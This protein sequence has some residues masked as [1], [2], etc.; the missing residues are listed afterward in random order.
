MQV[1]FLSLVFKLSYKNSLITD[2]VMLLNDPT[3]THYFYSLR[4]V[5]GG[6]NE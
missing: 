1:R 4:S 5:W 6:I 3:T 2:F